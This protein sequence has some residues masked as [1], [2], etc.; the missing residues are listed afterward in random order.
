MCRLRCVQ[1]QVCAGC[2]SKAILF[3]TSISMCF[4]AITA[5]N[6]KRIGELVRTVAVSGWSVREGKGRSIRKINSDIRHG[7][8]SYQAKQHTLNTNYY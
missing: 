7:P 2:R 1:A 4:V 5:K 6:T 8:M 3:S